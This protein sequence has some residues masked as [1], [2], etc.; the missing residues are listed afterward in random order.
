[1]SQYKWT[2]PSKLSDYDKL[3]EECEYMTG[4]D[5]PLSYCFLVVTAPGGRTI[6]SNLD[7]N[8]PWKNPIEVYDIAHELGTPMPEDIYRRI[9]S[10]YT[11]AHGFAWMDFT[12]RK[13]VPPTVDINKET[14][15]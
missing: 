11:D 7:D 6:Y 8:N 12:P 1:M 10:E 15:S 13:W 14:D 3:V 2:G 5:V 9:T 4:Y